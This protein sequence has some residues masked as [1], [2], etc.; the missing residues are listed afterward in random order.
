MSLS[1]ALYLYQYSHYYS[2]CFSSLVCCGEACQRMSV[3]R[4]HRTQRGMRSAAY[5]QSYNCYCSLKMSRK[6]YRAVQFNRLTLTQF[7]YKIKWCRPGSVDFKMQWV[8]R[9]T[10]EY[11]NQTSL[12]FL[13]REIKI[14][15]ILYIWTSRLSLR[16]TYQKDQ[17]L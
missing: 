9:D 10:K 8:G 13:Y 16:R 14:N 5:P 17:I 2:W 3:L 12:T 4:Q 1:S 6:S 11:N 7:I 15:N